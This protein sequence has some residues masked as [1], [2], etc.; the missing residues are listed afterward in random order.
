M[1]AD[2]R[3]I[4]KNELEEEQKASED[5]LNFPRNISP[6]M[7]TVRK[8]GR[9]KAINRDEPLNSQIHKPSTRPLVWLWCLQTHLWDGHVFLA[10]G[11]LGLCFELKTFQAIVQNPVLDD[12]SGSYHLV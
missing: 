6:T 10:H 9:E 12:H 5:Q 7:A 2:G 3:A 8:E 4:S 11:M 1:F